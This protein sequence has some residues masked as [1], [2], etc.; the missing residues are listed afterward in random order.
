MEITPASA[1]RRHDQTITE[2]LDGEAVVFDERGRT[3]HVLST[4]ATVIWEHLD[5]DLSIEELSAALADA[6]GA[7]LDVVRTDTLQT[8]LSFAEQ[9]LLGGTEPPPS[10]EASPE[11]TPV[12][13]EPTEPRFLKEPPHG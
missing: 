6:F 8:I 5:G 3:L 11:T 13:A 9:G 10:D 4:T 7:P 12:G 2:V 1:P